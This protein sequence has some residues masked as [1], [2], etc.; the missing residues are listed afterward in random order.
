[1]STL[2]QG[3]KVVAIVP[4]ALAAAFLAAIAALVTTGWRLRVSGVTTWCGLLLAAGVGIVLT[5]GAVGLLFPSVAGKV[6]VAPAG[7]AAL[8]ATLVGAVVAS[9]LVAGV[10]LLAARWSAPATWNAPAAALVA[11]AAL[12]VALLVAV[13][14]A[15]S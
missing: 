6:R 7:S 5:R 11:V 3:A 9:V 2:A 14:G 1:M 4:N 8:P 15:L 10:V 13:V 12:V